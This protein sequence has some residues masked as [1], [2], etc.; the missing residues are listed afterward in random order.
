MQHDSPDVPHRT[1]SKTELFLGC[2]KMGLLGFGGIAPWARHIIVEERRWLTDREFAEVLGMGQVL[3]GP[4]VMNASVIIGA[5]FQ[6]IPGALLCLLGQMAM[7][8]VIVVVLAVLYDRL[9]AIPEVRAGLIG[10]AA[11]SA[12][13]VLGTAIKMIRNIKPTVITL[14]IV[15]LGFAA[16]ALLRWPLVPVVVGLVALALLAAALGRRT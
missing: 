3:P 2:L 14:G 8:V 13:L 12:G 5:R 10:M 6:G 11:A 1:V 9:A 4:N 15:G 7:P 16:I